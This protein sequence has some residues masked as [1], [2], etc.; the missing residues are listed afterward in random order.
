MSDLESAFVAALR[1][2]YRLE[3]ELGR[4]GMAVVY[5]AHDLKHRRPVALKVIHS[6]RATALSVRPRRFRREVEL[7][8]R[9]QHPHV[10]GVYDS[11]EIANPDGGAGDPLLWFPL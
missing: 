3:R 5:L 9:L 2:R 8:A 1:D 11:G 6:D 7:A 4:G 10:L